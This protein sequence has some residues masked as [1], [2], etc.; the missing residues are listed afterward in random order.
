MVGRGGVPSTGVGAVAVNVTVTDPSAPS[1][2]TVFPSGKPKPNSSNLNFAAG[3]T[4]ANM[5]IVPVGP[6]GRISLTNYDGTTDLVVDV[7]AWFP[8]SDLAFTQRISVSSSGAEAG[9]ASSAPSVSADG[10][11]VVFSSTAP[12]LTAGD[13]DSATDIFVRDTQTGVTASMSDFDDIAGS[14]V[15]ARHLA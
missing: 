11:Y 6:D 3:Q 2:V 9:G 13:A 7:L 15:P 14:V 10:R 8:P 12:D 1:Y 4:V 5:T